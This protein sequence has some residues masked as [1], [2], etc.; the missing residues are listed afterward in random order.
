M[1]SSDR[2][3]Q[4]PLKVLK[5]K[6]YSLTFTLPLTL[7]LTLTLSFS[8]SL[9]LL[10]KV[11]K[12]EGALLSIRRM[13]DESNSPSKESL[14]NLSEEFYSSL[15][16]KPEWKKTITTKRMIAQKQDLCQLVR[17]IVAV[18]ES[19]NWSTRSSTASKYRSLRC[20]IS[21]LDPSS[22][23]YQEVQDHLLDS[24]DG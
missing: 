8:L 15:P 16:H 2:C 13:L 3:S 9:S 19:T 11:D 22:N 5:Q 6:R 18:G 21:H 20:E 14:E 4:Y 7:S 24:Q 12:A 23:E 10:L 1:G 17:D